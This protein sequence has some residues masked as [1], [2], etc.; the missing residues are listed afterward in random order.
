MLNNVPVTLTVVCS[1]SRDRS[2]L[3]LTTWGVVGGRYGSLGS[4]VVETD[5]L[6]VLETKDDM[7][8]LLLTALYGLDYDL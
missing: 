4:V 7:A 1:Q 3:R 6:P 5:Q 2:K 8:R